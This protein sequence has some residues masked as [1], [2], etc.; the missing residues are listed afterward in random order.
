MRGWGS[1]RREG[2]RGWGSERRGGVRGWGSERRGS[3][4]IHT[5]QELRDNP[6]LHLPLSRLSL[7]TDHIHLIY[8][9]DTGHTSLQGVT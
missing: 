2:V 5:G 3:Y 1:E 7:E 8:E 6:L 9:Q 4:T